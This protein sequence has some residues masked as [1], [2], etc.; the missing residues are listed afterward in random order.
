MSAIKKCL[1]KIARGYL[2]REKP[3]YFQPKHTFFLYKTAELAFRLSAN[4]D[5]VSRY[6]TLD[7]V[8]QTAKLVCSTEKNNLDVST[9]KSMSSIYSIDSLALKL[10]KS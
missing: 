4:V 7:L 1:H 10:N 5:T 2:P 9:A 8:R 3:V 6:V